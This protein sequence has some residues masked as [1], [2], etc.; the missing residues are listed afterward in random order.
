MLTEDFTLIHKGSRFSIYKKNEEEIIKIAE[1]TSPDAVSLSRLENEWNI[2]NELNLHVNRRAISKEVY[3]GRTAIKLANISGITLS[4]YLRSHKNTITEIVKIAIQITKQL[5]ILHNKGYIHNRLNPPHILLSESNFSPSLIGLGCA[6]RINSK[7]ANKKFSFEEFELAELAYI[8]PEQTGRTNQELSV[9]TDL[10]SLGA[11]LYHCLTGQTPFTT[12]DPLEQVHAHIAKIPKQAFLFSK[13][14]PNSVSKVLDRLLQKNPSERYSSANDLVDD[15]NEC[16]FQMQSQISSRFD[17]DSRQSNLKHFSFKQSLVGRKEESIVLR[18]IFSR[19]K[20][21]SREVVL[22][23]GKSGV[24]K[25]VFGKSIKNTVRE[26]E[27]EFLEGKFDEFNRGI[28]YLGLTQCLRQFVN[29]LLTKD[30]AT[31]N[32]WQNRL[33]EGIGSI[34]GILMNIIPELQLVFA[35][36][37]KLPLSDGPEAKNQLRYAVRSFIQTIADKNHPIVMM[38]DDIQWAD[39]DSLDLID[40]FLS[41]PQVSY[42]LLI[43]T[44]RKNSLPNGHPILSKVNNLKNS[45]ESNSVVNLQNLKDENIHELIE[46]T[47]EGSVDDTRQLIR[48]ILNITKGNAL[49]IT[50]F[51]SALVKEHALNFDAHSK[52]W[53]WHKDHI[54]RLNLSGG[55]EELI[56]QRINKIN[57]EVLELLSIASCVGNI[58]SISIL[59]YLFPESLSQLLQEA[60]YEGL[61]A[62]ETTNDNTDSKLYQFVH[63]RIREMAY[64]QLDEQDK[65]KKHLE[66]AKF[67]LEEYDSA[68]LDEH[69]FEIASQYNFGK[70]CISSPEEFHYAMQLNLQ[71]GIK[72]K[73]SGAFDP[74]LKYFKS[75]ISYQDESSWDKDYRLCLDLYGHA[76]QLA[77]LTG[78]YQELEKLSNASYSRATSILDTKPVVVANINALTAQKKHRNA[79]ALEL[80]FLRSLGYRIPTKGNKVHALLGLI[81]ITIKMRGKNSDKL[82]SLPI[83]TDEKQTTALQILGYALITAYFVEPDILTKIIYKMLSIS[84]DHGNA[85]DSAA[86][87]MGYGYILSGV[88]GDYN[89]GNDFGNLITKILSNAGKDELHYVLLFQSNIF[90]KHWKEPISDVISNL[91]VCY[92]KLLNLGIFESA[93]Y[94]I[95]S[96][97]YFSFFQSVDLNYL[98]KRCSDAVAIVSTLNQPNT[99][100]RIQMYH[101]AIINLTSN[102]ENPHLL[103]GQAYN[104]DEMIPLH[105]EDDISIA[106]HNVHF[107]KAY[108]AFL[109][110]NYQ[111]AWDE[112]G[113]A[114]KYNEA[115]VSSF[116]VPL[117]EFLEALIKVALNKGSKSIKANLKKLKKFSES[118]PFNYQRYYTLVQ[119]EF[120]KSSKKVA[121]ARVLYDDA[122]YQARQAGNLLDEALGWEL[123]GK[124]Y[125]Q[126]DR[127]DKASTCFQY[128]YDIHLKWGAISKA[129]QIIN[130]YTQSMKFAR[131]IS[132]GINSNE[133][134]SQRTFDQFSMVKSLQALSTE[135]DL[136]RLLEKMMSILI[137]NVGA[138]R[139]MLILQKNNEWDIVAEHDVNNEKVKVFKGQKLD[140]PE[141]EKEETLIPSGLVHYVIR[142]K[143]TVVINDVQR[144]FQ[145]K[146]LPYLQMRKPR[147]VLCMPLI[148]HKNL[149][150]IVYLENTLTTGAFTQGIQEGL[151]LLSKQLAISLENAILYKD[152]GD[153]VTQNQNLVSKLQVKVEEQEKTLKIF[154][155]FVPGPVVKKTLASKT[156]MSLLEGELREVA[157][158]FCDIRNFTSISEEL[159][160]TIVVELLNE[161]YA[162]M[163][164]IIQK[165]G[166]T[167]TNFIGD[168]I[169]AAFG[170]PVAIKRFE[171]NSVLCALEMAA[172]VQQLNERYKEKIDATIRIGIGINSGSVVAGILGSKAKLAYSIIG[173]IVNTAKRIESLTKDLNNGIL[174]SES[175]YLNSASKI[176]VK[177][178][179]PIQVKGKKEKLIVYEVIG[180]KVDDIFRNQGIMK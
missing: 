133:S 110:N 50:Q 132:I 165:Y 47:F 29:N 5:S 168:E 126:I 99:L 2:L 41:H 33:S 101:Q 154:S 137:E 127:D 27:G 92:E 158:M 176:D 89:G 23:E 55:L 139:G 163:T 14:I 134:R 80:Q 108:M 105:Y 25:T 149:I 63:D 151:N 131:T 112:I 46:D 65:A 122:I 53:S 37:E 141:E 15:L 103:K 179:E 75:G 34:A 102:Y 64:D 130:I 96:Y 166:G 59:E 91:D 144:D 142:T 90:L 67:L 177:G 43:T 21:G 74:A 156:E 44:F 117:F 148:N 107:L 56:A 79:L 82:S 94:S 77:S 83:N 84:L 171:E 118:A 48:L 28:P 72:A 161:F 153:K 61:I 71:A 58:F 180:K 160:P 31:L 129:N 40:S 66:I 162:L 175:I 164:E 85:P 113:K 32:Y 16:L 52:I 49:H 119:A 152:L 35:D 20:K 42:F 22:I 104:E 169:M 115:A 178:W 81:G 146:D 6:L 136:N 88:L 51:L 93:A 70:E 36:K 150:G 97:L 106:I 128:A 12:K 120:A 7:E 143:R 109:F 121:E 138:E 54:E 26:N 57:S 13:E 170:A 147:S 140:Q 76:A 124:F 111:L 100:H 62:E 114:K 17:A 116:F 155:Q 145:F 73:N 174:I 11:I 30:D 19:A 38:V 39:I 78:D 3:E 123:A 69:I 8:S 24:G 98:S 86:G 68:E 167:V 172:S 18:S 159:E 125:Q 87:Y 9:S 173:D 45:L 10:Y 157:V 60:V 1:S 95:H 135:L 4:Q